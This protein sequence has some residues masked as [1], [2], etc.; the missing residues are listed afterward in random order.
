[1]TQ[2]PAVR[3]RTVNNEDTA[4]GVVLRVRDLRKCFLDNVAND[5]VSID[6]LRG[7]VHCL[8]GE[9]GAGKST[10]AK[11]ICGM[12]R[13]DSGEILVNGKS[14]TIRSPRDAIALRI[15]VVH[16]HFV[17]VA[18]M[19]GLENII[20]GTR[21]TSGALDLKKAK[22]Q[23]EEIC[24][25]YHL[26]I[27]LDAR[28]DTLAVGQQQ[29]VE[30]LK[31]LYTGVD[32]LVLDEPTASLTP[33][34]AER[35]FAILRR[36]RT[37]GIAV[38][39]IT[40]KLYEVMDIAD[41]V[42]VMR[43]GKVMAT[44]LK[45]Q[46][47]KE[48]LARLMVGRDVELRISKGVAQVGGCVCS[49]K[50]ATLRTV[51]GRLALQGVSLDVRGGELVGIA[52]VGGNG[53][54]ELFDIL[55]GVARVSSGEVILNSRVINGLAPSDRMALGMASIPPDRIT[56][57]L[58]MGFALKDN[59]VFGFH[60]TNRFKAGPF[61]KAGRIRDFALE[62]IH[63]YDIVTS[64]P[65]QLTSQLSG[66]NL[67]K[68]ILARELSHEVAFLVASC[69]TRGLDVGATEFIR[70]RL[71]GLRDQGVA[72][73]LISEDL[74]EVLELADRF[75]VMFRGEI[76]G[77]FRPDEITREGIGLLMAGVRDGM[78]R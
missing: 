49:L 22:R 23:V 69:P 44:R 18:S 64:G 56:Q 8:L 32:I 28:I 45:T 27:D 73:L 29:W 41:R 65:D 11:C 76:M 60:H 24:R 78:G 52:G 20:V 40:H 51:E 62:C 38:L 30:I 7:E 54:D 25:S 17:L 2:H 37:E 13:A 67:Q 26:Q 39:L 71:V 9:N 4:R 10:L 14:V 77:V 35:L 43:H 31:A 47:T 3:A 21:S 66:G 42:T 33:Q 72:I 61:L 5:N 75:A 36:M 50:E 70:Q 12:Y 19:T 57:G 48:E 59:L 15:G 46:V 16:Q 55:V 74:D 58:L 34:E 53:Q 68:L 63:R 1:M 6:V